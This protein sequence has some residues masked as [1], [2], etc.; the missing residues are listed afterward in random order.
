VNALAWGG[1]HHTQTTGS[2]VL[3]N[4]ALPSLLNMLSHGALL[5]L[6]WCGSA[7]HAVVPWQRCSWFGG[8]AVL[9]MLWWCGGVAALLMLWWCGVVWQCCS[10]CGGVAVLLMLWWC[11]SAAHAVVV[12]HCLLCC[13]G[14][15][16]S[17][18][19]YTLSACADGAN[20]W[21]CR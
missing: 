3:R 7:A 2:R 13:G 19:L 5:M 17:L 16:L 11:G 6:W 9:H 8:V 1:V 20:A 12:W 4:I 18:N 15:A 21:Y 10:C 14:V